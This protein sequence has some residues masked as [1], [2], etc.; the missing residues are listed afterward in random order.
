[1]GGRKTPDLEAFPVAV[2]LII[3]LG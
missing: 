3:S 1:V 2:D